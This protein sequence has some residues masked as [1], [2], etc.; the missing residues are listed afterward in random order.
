MTAPTYKDLCPTPPKHKDFISKQKLQGYPY[1]L[2]SDLGMAYRVQRLPFA[3]VIDAAGTVKA[4]GLVNN[5]EQLESLFNALDSGVASVQQFAAIRE[6][7]AA[8]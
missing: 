7:E 4:K 6:M 8:E 2:S 5:R 1:V 3:V